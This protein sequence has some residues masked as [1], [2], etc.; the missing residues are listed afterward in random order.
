[1][2]NDRVVI[3]IG[4]SEGQIRFQ[5]T[6]NDLQLILSETNDQL[7]VR[8]WYNGSVYRVDS[9]DLANGKS[10]LE[11]QVPASASALLPL[12]IPDTMNLPADYQTSIIFA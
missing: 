5:R 8:N 2:D 7:T 11:S 9:F 10:L 12:P 6:G 1:M 4:V 3:G